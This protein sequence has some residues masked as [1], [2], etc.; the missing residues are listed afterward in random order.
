MK[1]M[2]ETLIDMI[3]LVVNFD[4]ELYKGAER[5]HDKR[6]RIGVPPRLK[7]PHHS[8]S[9]Q[10]GSS[11]LGLTIDIPKILHPD[12]FSFRDRCLFSS[13]T[14]LAAATASP[15]GVAT[16]SNA[17]SPI[18]AAA[19]CDASTNANSS[20]FFPSSFSLSTSRWCRAVST[21]SSSDRR[22]AVAISSSDSISIASGVGGGGGRAS[23]A[24]RACSTAT[25]TF[26]IS[27]AVRPTATAAGGC[28]FPIPG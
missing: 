12:T 3:T 20:R 4:Q 27:S 17:P 23:Y 11:I 7:E 5:C 10:G 9:T 22:I 16:E 28:C 14:S 19:T 2:S 24:A 18:D 8:F 13:L 26:S 15:P 1:V 25:S 6:Y 21:V